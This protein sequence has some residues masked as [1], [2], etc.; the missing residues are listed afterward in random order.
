[1]DR[2]VSVNKS[3]RLWE[4]VG[5]H[6]GRDVAFRVTLPDS[7]SEN[8][9]YCVGNMVQ[10]AISAF[11][12]YRDNES[13]IREFVKHTVIGMSRKYLDQNKV[14]RLIQD[15][16]GLA[17]ATIL[18]FHAYERQMATTKHDE[19]DFESPLGFSCYSDKK[20]DG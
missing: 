12:G 19:K 3:G 15:Y 16:I 8:E 9:A 2:S 4:I 1:M 17:A 14:L 13:V 18:G 20:L 11:F 7:Y 5:F 10:R 6:Q